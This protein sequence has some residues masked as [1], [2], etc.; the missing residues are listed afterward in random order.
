MKCF[1]LILLA[2]FALPIV[3]NASP[4]ITKET[5]TSEG[6]KRTYYLYVP[7]SVVKA[8]PA[9][10]LV[11][12]HGSNRNGLSLVEKWKD[13]A[14]KEGFIVA[15]PD[16]YNSSNWSIPG[17]GPVFLRDL[18][19][20]LKTKYP[21]NARRVYLFGHS[22][23]AGFALYISLLES[24]YFAATAIHAG[25]LRPEEDQEFFT[26]A[27]R[28]M[29]FALF[30]GTKDPLFPLSA[31]R[32]TRDAFKTRGFPVELTEIPNHDHWYYDLA[33]KINA[34][35]WE[36]LK[37]YELAEDPKYTQRDFIKK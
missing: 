16:A 28:K 36:F 37:K 35:V 33:P 27:T 18:V 25:A 17:D 23:G 32:A 22:G 4:K 29:P 21:V 10:L 2:I 9:P 31:V 6:K 26:A 11:T 34:Q 14:D 5:M 13:L 20:E 19:E 30:V 8:N 1:L 3:V 15:G 12:L 7:E 24:E